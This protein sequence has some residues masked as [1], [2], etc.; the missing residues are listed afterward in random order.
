MKMLS[1]LEERAAHLTAFKEDSD[2]N[3]NQL[4]L[5]PGCPCWHMQQQWAGG[6]LYRSNGNLTNEE[7]M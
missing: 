5:Y 7:W 2:Q 1:E 4:K 3:K 6:A